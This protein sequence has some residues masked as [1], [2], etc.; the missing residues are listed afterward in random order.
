[1]LSAVL[2]LRGIHPDDESLVVIGVDEV[3]VTIS[4]DRFAQIH[5]D[6]V[7]SDLFAPRA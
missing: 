4:P 7:P 2:Y 3:A 1:L 6:H 5:T